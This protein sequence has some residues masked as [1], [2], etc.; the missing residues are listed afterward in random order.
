MEKLRFPVLMSSI[1]LLFHSSIK[2]LKAFKT[3]RDLSNE[4]AMIRFSSA[5]IIPVIA[6]SAILYEKTLLSV[7]RSHPY[8]PLG[9]IP[10]HPQLK[11]LQNPVEGPAHQETVLFLLGLSDRCDPLPMLVEAIDHLPLHDVPN[12]PPS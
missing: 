1:Y 3:F 4:V 2:S 9:N 10:P 8:N 7:R 5:N 12:L 6:S 11:N